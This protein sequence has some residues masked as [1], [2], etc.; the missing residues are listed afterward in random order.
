MINYRLFTENRNF[1]F[2]VSLFVFVS[3][4][5]VANKAPNADLAGCGRPADDSGNGLLNEI[6][7]ANPSASWLA[8]VRNETI[9]EWDRPS[10]VI[11]RR[12][13]SSAFSLLNIF[14]IMSY[15]FLYFLNS[16]S[17]EMFDDAEAFN[18]ETGGD[19]FTGITE[20]VERGGGGGGLDFKGKSALLED[21]SGF[22]AAR[23]GGG[24]GFQSFATVSIY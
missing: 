20:L 15:C 16:S 8:E 5:S 24:G 7:A 19:S 22:I 11:V 1:T 13:V 9:S 2:P 17:H 14:D 18:T 21:S 6:L 4:L 23:G 12:T 10:M 3:I